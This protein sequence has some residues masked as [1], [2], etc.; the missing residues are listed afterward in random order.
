MNVWPGFSRCGVIDSSFFIV[1]LFVSPSPWWRCNTA[2]FLLRWHDIP[3]WWKWYAYIDFLR[4][5]WGSL[6]ANQ[7]GGSRNVVFIASSGANPQ[8]VTV[9][10]YY[11]TPSS[12]YG[13]WGIEVAFF[14][15]FFGFAF[16]ALR[17]VRHEKR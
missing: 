3:A 5:A 17:F 6:M 7:F 14:A 11:N 2:G 13:W 16:L 12:P 9:L 4:Y 15:A 10:D 1:C 8:N